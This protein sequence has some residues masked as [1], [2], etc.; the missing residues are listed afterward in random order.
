M[1]R[2]N[3]SPGNLSIAGFGIHY[4]WVIVGVAATMRLTV[5]AIRM[6]SGVL[7]PHLTNTFGWSYGSIGFAF[8]LQWICSGLCGP[9]AGWM[10]DRYGVR[11]TMMLGAALFM[12]GMLLTGTMSHLWQF[13]LYF[14]V[15]LS[16]S[17]AIFQVPLTVAVT[18][19]FRKHLGVGMG[20]LQSSQGLGPVLSV[21][22]VLLLLNELGLK[23]T[24]W[25]PG[26][27]GGVVLLLLIRA[28]HSEPGAIGLK[29]LGAP[30]TEM[31]QHLQRGPTAEMRTRVFLREVQRTG[32]FWNLIGIHFWGCAG[33]AIIMVFLVAIAM[34]R[35]LSEGAAAGLLVTLHVVST[36][37][38]LAVPIISDRM[39]SKGAMAAC[40]F[41]QSAPVLILFFAQ[42]AWAF[43][44]FAA[45]FGIG[46]GGEMS[47]FPIINRQYYGNAPIGTTYG[48]QVMGGGIGMAAGAGLGGLMWDLTGDYSSTVALSF[49]LSLVGAV[50]ILLL[51]NT[52]HHL[53]PHWEQALPVEAR[54][55]SS[56]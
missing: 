38:R 37:T 18:M 39:G 45:L 31:V 25:I 53:I 6:A 33:H 3:L 51:P 48:W 5:S 28:F 20:V 7:V 49:V 24:F 50:S 44:T 46:F 22:L 35:G 47:A 55:S 16:A 11:R 56:A 43:Y 34:D 15:L 14:G 40:F 17:M 8:A 27:V 9:A 30:K 42:D 32:A 26:I 10:G 52:S 19:W 36:V 2:V 54:S 41:L 4:A 29:P 13:Y 12:A 23:W 21:P 1:L